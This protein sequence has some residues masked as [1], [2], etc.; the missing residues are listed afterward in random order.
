MARALPLYERVFDIEYPLPKLDLL[1]V[2]LPFSPSPFFTDAV[3]A[4]ADMGSYAME[5]WVRS[6]RPRAG[7]T[8]M[9]SMSRD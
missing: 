3:T 9:G 8:L 7:R 2:R 1:I 5:N 4:Q 6:R